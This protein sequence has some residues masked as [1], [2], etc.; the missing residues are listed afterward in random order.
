MKIVYCGYVSQS[1]EQNDLRLP[2]L[3]TNWTSDNTAR[4][5]RQ[6]ILHYCRNKLSNS[7]VPDT[8]N[9]SKAPLRSG[10]KYLETYSSSNATAPDPEER[11]YYYTQ[12]KISRQ[13]SSKV[14]H[15]VKASATD[16]RRRTK[17]SRQTP[18]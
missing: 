12:G 15:K 1:A 18:K 14:K 16:K 9:H 17:N 4:E 2:E 8:K 3:V 13:R 10:Q 5:N 7:V 11:V 6:N